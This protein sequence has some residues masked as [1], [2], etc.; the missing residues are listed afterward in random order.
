MKQLIIAVG[1]ILIILMSKQLDAQSYNGIIN[2]IVSSSESGQP[3][4]GARVSI[5]GTSRGAVTKIDGSYRIS[6]VEP[7]I[8]SLQYNYIGFSKLVITGI[9]VRPGEITQ[10][11]CALKEDAIVKEEIVITARSNKSAEAVLL[12][13]RQNSQS[14]SD[15][16][17]AEQISRGGAGDAAEAINKVTGAT[18]A[19]GKHVYIRGLGDRYSSTQLNG[20]QLPSADPD[21]K[22]VHL[23]LFPS[24][25]IENI[26]TIKTASPDRPGDFTGGTVDI[27]TKSFPDRFNMNAS[28]S[29]TYNT[30]VSGGSMLTMQNSSSDWLG[31]DDGQRAVPNSVRQTLSKSGGEIPSLSEV[32][33]DAEKATLLNDLS[34]SFSKEMVPSTGVVPMNS[35]FS[36]STGDRLD[37][38]GEDFGFLASLSHSSGSKVYNKGAKNFYS[39]PGNASE[40]SGLS[41]D[42]SSNDSRSVQEVAWGGMVNLAYDINQNNRISANYMYSQAGESEA[43]YQSGQDVNYGFDLTYETRVLHYTERNINASQLSGE[44]KIAALLNSTLQWQ[45][46]LSKN[47]QYEPDLRF[48]TSDYSIDDDGNK[49]YDIDGSLYKYPSRYFRDLS[50]N[51]FSAR[52]D[53]ELP[54]KEALDFPIKVKVGANYSQKDRMFREERFD[55]NQNK[56]SDEFRKTGDVADLMNNHTG[57]IDEKTLPNEQSAYIMGNYIMYYGPEA[58]SYDGAQ[59]VSASYAMVDFN[60]LPSLRIVAGARYETTLLKVSSLDTSN[61]VGRLDIG[62]FLPSANLIY[63]INSKMNLRAAYGKTLARPSFREFASY[64]SFEYV[65]GFTLVGNNSLQR[66]LINNFDLRWEWFMNPGE[67]ISASAFYKDFTNPIERSII[68]VNREVQYKNVS[69]ASLYGLEFEFRKNLK[70]LHSDLHHFQL[71][72]NLTLVRSEVAVSAAELA[73]MQSYDENA[74]ATRELQGQSPYVVNFDFSYINEESGTSASL[75]YNIFGSRLAAVSLGGTPD[76]YE[77]SRPELNLTVSQ[78]IFD[79]LRFKLAAKNILNSPFEQYQEFKGERYTNEY[80]ELGTSISFSVAYSIN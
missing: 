18:T 37:V 77:A 39:L 27:S 69:E 21:K 26:T 51:L 48:F 42:V 56:K 35:S 31:K 47:T 54:L 60:I 10:L 5:V 67:I 7:G 72:A 24:S 79:N 28:V 73:I 49:Q 78:R 33:R 29:G 17:G 52:V 44:H 15:A 13:N 36:L 22:S 6:D 16:I 25:M 14:F 65:G 19:S 41:Q 66:S 50:E 32:Y 74:K 20:A 55:F 62:D 53:W 4:I 61:S 57:I 38:M 64:S 75:Y 76:I 30:L 2:G 40:A 34:N 8:Y 58:A 12:K 43:R 11:N 23:D 46:S 59:N 3:L 68:N 71:G 63:T 45:T 80:Y 70:F 1:M 9:E